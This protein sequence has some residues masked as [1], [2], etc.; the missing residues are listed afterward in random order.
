[1]HYICV[2]LELYSRKDNDG[3]RSEHSFWNVQVSYRRFIFTG[4]ISD[5]RSRGLNK[6]VGR[7]TTAIYLFID[8]LQRLRKLAE[9]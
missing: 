4:W 3:M 6:L 2:I 1:M 5:V 9:R 8:I 7:N